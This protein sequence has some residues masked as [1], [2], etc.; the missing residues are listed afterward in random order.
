MSSFASNRTS[1]AHVDGVA[2]VSDT[3][4]AAAAAP[5][6]ATEERCGVCLD[7]RGAEG[8]EWQFAPCMHGY[9]AGCLAMLY[10]RVCPMCRVPLDGTPTTSAATPRRDIARPAP[11]PAPAHRPVAAPA[12]R[13]PP[14]PILVADAARGFAIVDIRQDILRRVAA[15]RAALASIDALLSVDLDDAGPVEMLETA[16]VSSRVMALASMCHIGVD[17]P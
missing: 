17:A 11:G 12:H 4:A 1:A 15:A 10:E 7:V 14:T 9:H 2:P 16:A 5:V 3:P 6:A 13:T 8:T